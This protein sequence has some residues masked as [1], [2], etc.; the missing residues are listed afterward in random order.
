MYFYFFLTYLTP[1][2][3]MHT[4]ATQLWKLFISWNTMKLVIWRIKTLSLKQIIR[5]SLS[6]RWFFPNQVAKFPT[7]VIFHMWHGAN[8]VQCTGGNAI[9]TV[10]AP[11]Q[12]VVS[13]LYKW[14]WCLQAIRCQTGGDKRQ[15]ESEARCW[16]PP[17]LLTQLSTTVQMGLTMT[18][19]W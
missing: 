12:C 8:N 19:H 5:P 15:M 16:V 13:V 11:W 6:I 18:V 17:V 2:G 1:K 10:W 7:V 3:F 14:F 4:S 9:T